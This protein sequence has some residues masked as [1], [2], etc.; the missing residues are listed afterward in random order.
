MNCIHL[1]CQTGFHYIYFFLTDQSLTLVFLSDD[2]SNRFLYEQLALSDCNAVSVL[3]E[4]LKY[5]LP[6]RSLASIIRFW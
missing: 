6:V 1:V 2:L 4:F 3:A 5:P